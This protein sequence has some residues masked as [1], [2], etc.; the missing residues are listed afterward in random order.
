MLEDILGSYVM[1]LGGSWN[2]KLPLVK[3]SNNSKYQAS[4]GMAL[5]KLYVEGS[6]DHQST[7][8]KLGNP[9]LTKRSSQEKRRKQ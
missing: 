2:K 9:S 8:M 4:M 5:M 1:D 6:V 7:G 3:F